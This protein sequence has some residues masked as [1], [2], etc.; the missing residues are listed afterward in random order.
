MNSE[1]QPLLGHSESDSYHRTIPRP[2]IRNSPDSAL[3]EVQSEND[4]GSKESLE[5]YNPA[6]HRSLEHPTSNLD[7]LIHLLKGNIGTGILAMPNA[8]KNAGLYVGLI[9]TMM[10]GLICTHCMHTL[11]KCAHELCNRCQVPSLGF[12]EVCFVAFE[13]GPVGL[14]RYSHTARSLVNMFLCITQI[15]FC[16][17]YFLFVAVN[18]QQVIAQYFIKLDTRLYLLMLLIPMI[19]LNLVRNLKYLTPISLLA[20]VLTVIGKI[21]FNSSCRSNF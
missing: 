7:T 17:V 10:M 8:F 14:R 1:K 11:V 2:D 19:I 5:D 20:A 16:C 13:T 12:S 9:G 4:D 15:G 18:L 21:Y 6:N 3:V